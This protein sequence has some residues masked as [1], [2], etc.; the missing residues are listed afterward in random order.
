MSLE[1]PKTIPAP[2]GEALDDQWYK[3]F[4]KI[5]DAKKFLN[6]VFQA[7]FTINSIKKGIKTKKEA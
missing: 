6:D 3:K 5:D 1:M 7:I 2:E 4:E